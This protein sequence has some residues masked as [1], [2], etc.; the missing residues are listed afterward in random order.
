MD[1]GCNNQQ[2]K[3]FVILK[4]ESKC[5]CVFCVCVHKRRE[6]RRKRWR[7]GKAR[8]KRNKKSWDLFRAHWIGYWFVCSFSL[9]FI[10]F[11]CLLPCHWSDAAVSKVVPHDAVHSLYVKMQR[12]HILPPISVADILIMVAVR[13]SFLQLA[14]GLNAKYL[15]AAVL[16]C[17][18]II[19]ICSYFAH[20][21]LKIS[22]SP[23]R[24]SKYP[25]DSLLPSLVKILVCD[26]RM[27]QMWIPCFTL[28]FHCFIWD[29]KVCL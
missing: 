27:V 23:P 8:W 12:D 7:K 29:V 17:M 15:F 28:V 14:L 3:S 24:Y 4:V 22:F 1:E 26:N 10:S 25:L 2:K 13:T 16:C 20:S 11:I 9:C 21:T 19:L 5:V 6:K 18:A